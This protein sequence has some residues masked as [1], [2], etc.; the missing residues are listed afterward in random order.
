[1]SC[2]KLCSDNGTVH[3][4]C[5]SEPGDHD[6]NGDIWVAIG[7]LYTARLLIAYIAGTMRGLVPAAKDSVTLSGKV[8]DERLMLASLVSQW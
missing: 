4:H 1:M 2:H 7:R 3:W 6:G 8:N 5:P